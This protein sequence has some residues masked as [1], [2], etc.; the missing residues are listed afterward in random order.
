MQALTAIEVAADLEAHMRAGDPV[1]LW[2]A[3]G[4]GK[5]ETIQQVAAKAGRPVFEIR[6]NL[7]ESVDITGLPN[8]RDDET[9]YARPRMFPGANY[10]G[11]PPVIFWDEANQGQI[12]TLNAMMQTVLCNMAGPHAL[13]PGTWHVAA[14]NRREDKAAV[15]KVPGPLLKR[16]GHMH[17]IA[18]PAAWLHWAAGAG[19]ADVVRAFIKFRPLLLH[20]LSLDADFANKMD[21]NEPTDANPR[22]WSR[23]ARLLPHTGVTERQ[24]RVGQILG[25]AIAE[26]FEA[27]A[28][29]YAQIP[30][31][32]S[33]IADPDGAPVS[34]DPAML[35]AVS[36]ALARWATPANFGQIIKYAARLPADFAQ[37]M[38]HEAT[39]L[40]P[41]LIE[42]RA[43]TSYCVAA[44]RVIL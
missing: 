36:F 6:T 33:I 26:E 12:P 5:T 38:T 10:T 11:P 1:W 39:R 14:G 17:M 24:R 27:F 35:Y 18:D 29:V 21:P 9:H 28:R 7:I 15:Q 2:G 31:I 34:D 20:P 4:I 3:S 42:T 37:A 13:P 41:E 30:A 44:Q 32:D 8:I 23:V 43:Y 22:N 40:H 25:D 16:F 19:I